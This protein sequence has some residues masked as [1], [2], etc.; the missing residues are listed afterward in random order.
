MDSPDPATSTLEAPTTEV[1]T[2]PCILV[3]GM[4]R[5]GTSA[6][7]R[8]LSFCDLQ[9]P[10]SLLGA[11]EGNP[12]GHWESEVLI[13]FNNRLLSALGVEWNDWRDA[14]FSELSRN[15]IA[16]FRSELQQLIR[17]EFEGDKPF[18]LK[19]PRIC[20]LVGFYIE[21]LVE[22]GITPRIALPF[23][24]PIEVAKSLSHRD[25]DEPEKSYIVWLLHILEA[26]YATRKLPRVFSEYADLLADPLKETLRAHGH[27]DLPEVTQ[28]EKLAANLSRFVDPELKRSHTDKK[29]SFKNQKIDD[30]VK[31]VY[32]ALQRM[33]DNA[34]DKN[35]LQELDFIR[36]AVTKSANLIRPHFTS[37][38]K[39]LNDTQAALQSETEHSNRR[40]DHILHLEE[41]T[42]RLSQHSNNLESERI[43]LSGLID[44]LNTQNTSLET[45]TSDANNELE[46][47]NKNITALTDE[48]TR[49][50]ARYAEA[51]TDIQHLTQDGQRMETVIREIRSSTSWRITRPIR[52]IKTLPRLLK[53]LRDRRVLS[54]SSLFDRA[55]Y[56]STYPD[57]AASGMSPEKH[58]LSAGAAEG[59]NPSPDFNTSLYFELNRDVSR[60]QTNPLV[61][62]ERFGRK[63]NRAWQ[64]ASTMSALSSIPAHDITDTISCNIVPLS[65]VIRADSDN[66]GEWTMTGDDPAFMV[67]L[68]PAQL[69]SG[70]YRMSWETKSPKAI[71]HPKIYLPV[72]DQ[73][74]EET[75]QEIFPRQDQNNR[76]WADI[77]VASNT[78]FLRFDPSVSR[79]ALSLQSLKIKKIST[80]K[81]Y[82]SAIHLGWRERVTSPLA[83]L[84]IARK[85]FTSLIKGGPKQLAADI[86][87]S[88]VQRDHVSSYDQWIA[89]YDTLSVSDI[90]KIKSRIEALEKP[91]L[92]SV[93]VPVYNPPLDL[94]EKA[95]KSVQ[96]QLYPNWELCIANDCSTAPGVA[97]LL[98]KFS[99]E[100]IKIK[101]IHRTENGHISKATNS[102]LELAKGEWIALLDHDDLLSPHALYHVAEAITRNPNARLFYS[103]EDKVDLTDR[104][105]DPY[106]KSDWNPDLFLS[107]NLITHL[108]VYHSDTLRTIKGFRTG[109]EGAQDYDLALRFTREISPD[110]IVHI[111]HILYHWRVMP[112]STAMSSDEKPYAMI[113]GKK[114]LNDHLAAKQIKAHA[115]LIGIGYHIQ[116]E[117]PENPPLT[118]IIIPTRNAHALVKQCIDSILELTTYPNYEILL[119]DNGSDDPVSL[120]YFVD[121]EKH[122]RIKVLRDDS[123]F[124]YSAINNNAVKH[125]Q[126]EIIA[127]VNNDIEVISEHWL[128]EMVSTAIQP[129]V[130]AV[131][132]MLYYPDDTIQHA[133]VIM[134]LGGL[135]AH[136]HS[137]LP[138]NSFGYVGRAALKQTL[139]AVTAACLVVS[140]ENFD[141]VGGLDEDNLTVAYNDV[142]FCLK[143]D[144]AGLRN[145]WTPHAELY[146]HESATRGYEVSPEKQ[147]RFEKEKQYMLKHWAEIIAK[148]PAYSPNLTLDFSNFAYA[149]PPRTTKPWNDE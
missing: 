8:A 120:E 52:A 80:R 31:R 76:Y 17:S 28:T 23:R 32:L 78:N 75:A 95:I 11:N 136:A 46:E 58:Y 117:L 88:T 42:E 115:E 43:R 105:H 39:S 104:R 47:R 1:A 134:G 44:I 113:A 125:A 9:L 2:R 67:D 36:M 61:H 149:F 122:D 10:S 73:L 37:L 59:R 45:R 74:N 56:L 94:L 7:T 84:K 116:Y 103:D 138:R 5:S 129:G 111:P 107:H 142:D 93:I 106:F 114:A 81:Y 38:E 77:Q 40:A 6:L 15:Q 22:M 4:H 21:T 30:W 35:A 82:S 97:E 101:V 98:D 144:R 66:A 49:L 146:H 96:G 90:S 127:L 108:G 118:S 41:Q 126:G 12:A 91:P 85:V 50:N 71:I 87:N 20:R 57:V 133:G 70:Y 33:V 63:E 112:G 99:S 147:A 89:L 124:N 148:D 141:S 27:L 62:F 69:N 26:E 53:Q 79:G 16:A 123:P 34:N 65:D 19:D 128:D 130:G 3:L 68:K 64:E 143:L 135:A 145:I 24:H 25:G 137:N 29:H 119:V 72:G 48:L 86:R 92:I 110:Q 102:A 83:A 132:A 109:V 140:R 14:D 100:D 60:S 121:L 139:S 131:G 13:A 51:T 54:K 55:F 18:I